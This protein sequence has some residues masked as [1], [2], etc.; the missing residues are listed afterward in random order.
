MDLNK[1]Q[2]IVYHLDGTIWA[3]GPNGELISRLFEGGI[4]QLQA[5]LPGIPVETEKELPPW[6]MPVRMVAVE[7]IDLRNIPDEIDGVK[8]KMGDR[9]LLV[10]QSQT[11]ANGIFRVSAQTWS[12][13]GI[14]MPLAE[15]EAR[16]SVSAG[17][18]H[19]GSAW[20]WD[21]ETRSW[22]PT[23]AF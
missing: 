13:S 3:H 1:I 16:V 15:G 8:L 14:K 4:R 21:P 17:L 6:I 7:E 12:W 5:L 18:R 11:K 9:I 20:L 19:S 22:S 10:G 2:S 23:A